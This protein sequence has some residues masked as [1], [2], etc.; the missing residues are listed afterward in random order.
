MSFRDLEAKVF[1]HPMSSSGMSCHPGREEGVKIISWPSKKSADGKG[2]QN[3]KSQLICSQFQE[4]LY[5]K[6]AL[7][8]SSKV[9]GKSLSITDV[10]FFLSQ[11]KS[12]LLPEYVI[13]VLL[14]PMKHSKDLNWDREALFGF[15]RLLK[16]V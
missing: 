3:I 8:F 14:I 4:L 7:F 6:V 2:W 1:K 13:P 16:E 10:A 9:K 12:D 15:S 11:C 5:C